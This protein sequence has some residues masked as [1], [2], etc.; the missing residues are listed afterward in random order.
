MKIQLNLNETID[1]LVKEFLSC[2]EARFLSED[3]SLNDGSLL[4]R[5]LDRF[6]RRIQ[7]TNRLL[8]NLAKEYDKLA[9]QIIF[10]VARKQVQLS[11][12]AVK[13]RFDVSFF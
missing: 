4:N 10:N 13:K 3:G 2:I 5:A 12:E 1:E 7:S 9:L 8:P 6:Y 11:S